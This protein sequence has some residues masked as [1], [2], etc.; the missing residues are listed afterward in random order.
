MQCT[1]YY[2]G[3]CVPA[4]HIFPLLNPSANRTQITLVELCEDLLGGLSQLD[5]STF[6]IT[7]II[8]AQTLR[9]SPTFSPS[10]SSQKDLCPVLDIIVLDGRVVNS[11]P[12]KSQ[13]LDVGFGLRTGRDDGESPLHPT[14]SPGSLRLRWRRKVNHGLLKERTE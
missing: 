8:K 10:R 14:V 13:R 9:R 3:V 6:T 5:M 11:F 1:A 12:V 4:I 2:P 7:P